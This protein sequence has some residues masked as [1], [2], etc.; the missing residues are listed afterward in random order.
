MVIDCSKFV[1]KTGVSKLVFCQIRQIIWIDLGGQIKKD[2]T[3]E[4]DAIIPIF[5]RFLHHIFYI[6]FRKIFAQ[7]SHSYPNIVSTEI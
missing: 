3:V 5:I 7:C 1:L 6:L 2:L 4:V